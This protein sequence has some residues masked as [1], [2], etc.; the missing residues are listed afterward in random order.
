MAFEARPLRVQLPCKAVTVIG[1]EEFDA[2]VEA[3]RYWRAIALEYQA[4]LKTFMCDDCS[5]NPSEP[6]CPNESQDPDHF[7]VFHIRVLPLIRKQL[8]QRLEEIMKAE[9]AAARATGGG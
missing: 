6:L 2:H 3:H 8:E 4:K 5:A 7:S 9:E 1:A